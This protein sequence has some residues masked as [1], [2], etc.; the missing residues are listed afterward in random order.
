MRRWT[1]PLSSPSTLPGSGASRSLF[2]PTVLRAA[3]QGHGLGCGDLN[4]DGRLD[5]VLPG[6]WLEQ[7]PEG[8][9]G[10]WIWH[11]EF[12]LGATSVPILVADVNG[13]GLPD[14]IA[15]QGH[16]YGLHWWEQRRDAAGQ[17]T[18]V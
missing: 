7:P 9:A 6:G 2:T 10:E 14:L 16:D 18:W 8:L 11:P 17:R 1:C 4:G 3:P 5:L 12:N 15:G 13:D